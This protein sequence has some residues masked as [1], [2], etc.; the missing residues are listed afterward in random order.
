MR[1]PTFLQLHHE[2]DEAV[3]AELAQGLLEK[4]ARVAPKFLYDLLGS[5]LFDA[6]TE[7]PEY[8][9][10]RTERW[11][12]EHQR[13]SIAAVVG[14]GMTLVDLGAGNCEKAAGWFDALVP[15]RYVAVDISVEYLR[16]ALGSLQQRHADLPM[17]GLGLDF[18]S[19]LRLPR[20]VGDGPRLLFYPGSSIGNFTPDQALDLLTQARRECHGGGLLIGVDL[21]KDAALLE[22]AYDDPL[23]VTAAFN[24]NLLNRLNQLLGCDAQVADF[25]HVGLYNVPASRIEMHLQ[26]RRTLTLRWAGGERQLQAGERI[27]TENSYKYTLDGFDALL[28]AAGFAQ[29]RHWTD[30][31]QWFAVFSARG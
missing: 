9:P 4:S 20:E 29:I 16:Q 15:Q 5:R 14:R 31:A 1:Q 25:K 10:T 8:Y 26:A 12:F 11:I 22:A 24:R 19:Q 18:S 6:I 3:R 17:L 7:L 21:V 30:P 28:A 27:H 13:A 23:Q 2:T